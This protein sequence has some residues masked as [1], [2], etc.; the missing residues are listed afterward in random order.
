MYVKKGSEFLFD[1]PLKNLEKLYHEE[2]NSKAK[3]RLQCAVLRKKGKSQIFISDVVG[4]AQS[5]VSAILKRF[6]KKGIE[7]A[8][9]V[10]QK[11][12]PQKLNK[13]QL[14]QLD[15][16]LCES[17]Q[18]QKIPFIA[19]TTKLVHSLIKQKYKIDYT[20]RQ[21]INILK[22]LGFSSQKPRP[23]HVKA[24]KELQDKFKKNSFESWGNIKDMDMRSVIWTK[25]H[26]S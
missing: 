11:G 3:I 23:N 16:I 2:K 20:L 10:K 6:E 19:W 24:N 15:K 22:K 9:A 17:P 8:Y 4:R 1:I 13:R 26:S 14:K 18:K 12:Q 7:A 5:S 21:V 25:V